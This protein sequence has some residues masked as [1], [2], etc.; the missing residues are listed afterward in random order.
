M[1]SKTNLLATLVSAIVM[2]FLGYLIWGL[3]TVN[4]FTEHTIVNSMKEVPDLGLIALANLIGT[5]IM[6]TL[7]SKWARGHHSLGQGFEFGALIGAFVGLSMGLLWY[8]TAN[9]MDLTAHV[10]EAILDIAFYGI[11]G[12]CVALVYQKMAK[13]E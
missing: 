1:F 12:I 3:A 10:V 5:F 7:Y 9:M 11:I 8:A 13:K 4:F 2:F 6:S